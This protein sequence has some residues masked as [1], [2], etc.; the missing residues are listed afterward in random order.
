MS[1]RESFDAVVVG[2][3]LIGAACADAL[4]GRGLS[5]CLLE[6]GSFAREASWAGAGILHPIHPWNYPEALQPLL[7][8]GPASHETVAE[9]L[10]ADT[11]IEVGYRRTGL[12]VMGDALD[13]LEEWCAGHIPC[14]RAP[15]RRH[16]PG[17]A[18]DGEALWLPEAAQVKSHKLA[19]AYLA[20]ARARGA[21][22]R[23]HCAATRLAPGLVETAAGPIEAGRTILCAGAWSSRLAPETAV[24]PVRGQILLVRRALT[25]MVVFPD[26]EYVVPRADGVALF[27]STLEKVGF[28]ARPTQDGYARLAGRAKA[29]LGCETALEEAAWAGLRPGTESGMPYLG[30]SRERSDLLHAHG[31]YRNGILLAPITSGILADLATG[32]APSFDL[33]AFPR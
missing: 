29:L 22:L 13:Q 3:G 14:E 28:E 30:Q 11:G 9:E 4:A 27:G 32:E 12:L 31:H 24:E 6:A 26:G 21:V 10:R 33:S 15:A 1:T 25:R 8:A 20:R 2:G 18:I 5:T 7:R 16:E 17:L 23:E 19:E